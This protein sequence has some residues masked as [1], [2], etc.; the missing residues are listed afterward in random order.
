MVQNRHLW[1]DNW[2]STWY[3]RIRP[4]LLLF[5]PFLR[6]GS[7]LEPRSVLLLCFGMQENGLARSGRLADKSVERSECYENTQ[8]CWTNEFLLNRALVI[9]DQHRSAFKKSRSFGLAIK[10]AFILEPSMNGRCTD[11]S[12]ATITKVWNEYYQMSNGLQTT[13]PGTC[14]DQYA[15]HRSQ[16][17]TCQQTIA[18]N[19]I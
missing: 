19:F 4:P 16:L 15:L 18:S 10:K 5:S 3:D 7:L 8:P 12:V 14:M 6:W 11:L 1:D 2:P 17:L 9:P 13:N